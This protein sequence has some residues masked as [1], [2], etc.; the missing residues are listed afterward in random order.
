VLIACN[1]A[2]HYSV[3]EQATAVVLTTIRRENLSDNITEELRILLLLGN[4]SSIA[5]GG[6][7]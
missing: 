5:I 2:L 1:S 3:T 7:R 6:N 4:Y